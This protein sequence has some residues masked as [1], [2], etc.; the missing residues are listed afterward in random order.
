[1]SDAMAL[2]LTRHSIGLEARAE[3]IP[4]ERLDHDPSDRC[5]G[6]PPVTWYWPV[7]SIGNLHPVV[8]VGWGAPRRKADGT[9]QPHL[10][11]DI[12]YERRGRRYL[13]AAYPP[14]SPNGTWRYFMPDGVPALAAGDAIVRLTRSSCSA[15]SVVLQHANGWVSYYTHLEQLSI[16]ADQTVVA[17]QPIGVIGQ[18]AVGHRGLRHLHFE[19]WSDGRRGSAVDPGPYLATWKRL[20]LATWWPPAVRDR[21]DA[22]RPTTAKPKRTSHG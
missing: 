19:L 12:V 22:Q 4:D 15:Y 6:R 7:P 9:T 11:A 5:A 1:M 13:V 21:R 8:A 17:G 2:P 10:G 16:G 14:G 20:S 18:D 3:S